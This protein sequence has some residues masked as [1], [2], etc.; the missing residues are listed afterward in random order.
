MAAHWVE[1]AMVD[2]VIKLGA[3]VLFL[4]PAY[5]ALLASFMR[6]FGQR[7]PATINAPG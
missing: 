7:L 6:V 3:S 2:Y 5:G 1:I 4:V